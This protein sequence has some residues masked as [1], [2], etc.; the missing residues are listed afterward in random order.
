MN[1]T[2]EELD[3][4]WK[5]NGRR[6]QST[7]A[8]SFSQE[9]VDI[10][11]IENSIADL[12]EQV[13]KR[14]QQINSQ[15]SE[16]EALEARIR[17]MEQRLK[18]GT[19]SING[20]VTDNQPN[21]SPR[22][23]RSPVGDL[24]TDANGAPPPPEKDYRPSQNQGAQQSKYS[25]S[26]PGTA[27]QSQQAVPG[28]LPPTPVGSEGEYEPPVTHPPRMPVFSRPFA[29]PARTRQG[30]IY[31]TGTGSFSG[32]QGRH[33]KRTGEDDSASVKSMS[34]SSTLA[35]YVIIPRLDG[36]DDQDA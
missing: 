15:T 29:P 13:D 9:L 1:M 6:P 10:F 26:R 33:M 20:I 22:A 14:K 17:E 36:D 12:D 2:D 3:R 31:S 8:R 25:G 7:I 4:D 24:F 19:S 27:K 34:G 21:G 35:D 28:A 18:Q 11:R 16:L 5:P 23:Q 30:G 32:A